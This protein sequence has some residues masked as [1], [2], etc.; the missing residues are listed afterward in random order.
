MR[1]YA[2][3]RARETHRIANRLLDIA[4]HR[5]RAGSGKE[6]TALLRIVANRLLCEMEEA[7]NEA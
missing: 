7:F 5:K 3:A 6:A 1:F 4:E 2:A